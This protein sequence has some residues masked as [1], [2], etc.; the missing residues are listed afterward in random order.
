M[1]EPMRYYS[2]KQS[3][4]MI[5][6]DLWVNENSYPYPVYEMRGQDL[7]HVGYEGKVPLDL[8]KDPLPNIPLEQKRR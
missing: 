8:I 2:K 4:Y 3:K 5:D 6:G 1:R 7:V